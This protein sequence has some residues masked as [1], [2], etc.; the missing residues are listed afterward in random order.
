MPKR[1][2]QPAPRIRLKIGDRVRVISGRERGKEGEVI[3]VL[4]DKGRVVVRDANIVT[5]AERPTQDNPQGGFKN[6][7]GSI[8]V[9][10][11]QILDP[12]SGEPSRIGY[13]FEEG[14]KVRISVKS[15]TR[16]DQE[17]L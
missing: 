10:N 11:V 9:S 4:R 6:F 2:R 17:E 7:E 5:K 1:Y 16:L 13:T 3:E 8:H 15:G 12:Q 14:K